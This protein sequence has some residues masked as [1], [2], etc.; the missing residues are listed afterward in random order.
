MNFLKYSIQVGFA[1]PFEFEG[2]RRR[3]AGKRYLID[4]C[5][6]IILA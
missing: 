2:G 4:V 5:S 1:E 3:V 6:V